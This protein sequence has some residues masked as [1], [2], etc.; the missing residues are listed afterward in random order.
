M[1]AFGVV[2]VGLLFLRGEVVE[3]AG[4]WACTG[5]LLRPV[6]WDVPVSWKAVQ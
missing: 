6:L 3:E 1:G 5:I 2:Y 4:K